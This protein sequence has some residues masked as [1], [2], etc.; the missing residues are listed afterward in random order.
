MS[1]RWLLALVLISAASGARAAPPSVPPA[2]LHAPS[3]LGVS[4]PAAAPLPLPPMPPA[5][6]TAAPPKAAAKAQPAPTKPEAAPAPKPQDSEEASRENVPYW[7]SLRADDVYLRQGPGT[8]YPIRWVYH[9]RGLPVKVIRK[10]D[11]W[12]LVIDPVGDRGWIHEVLLSLTRGFMV[13]APFVML[14][15]EPSDGA[16]A[17]AKLEK[18]VTGR[19]RRCPE[20]NWCRVEAHGYAGWVPRSDIYGVDPG[21][22]VK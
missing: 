8:Q 9:R 17:V 13:T 14:R 20:G 21:E 4:H 19:L 11:V 3:Q 15:A 10:F 5:A 7:E 2:F 12:R 22:I 6:P 18:G 16:R 1:G